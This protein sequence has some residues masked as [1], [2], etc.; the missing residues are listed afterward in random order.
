MVPY[1]PLNAV[2]SL[3]GDTIKFASETIHNLYG[4]TRLLHRDLKS[5]SIFIQSFNLPLYF[6]F[7]YQHI[8]SSAVDVFKWR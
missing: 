1:L 7:V 5:T 8:P 4:R 3:D 2:K 6:Q